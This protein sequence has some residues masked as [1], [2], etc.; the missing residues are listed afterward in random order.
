MT[1]AL[2]LSRMQ[3]V[4]IMDLRSNQIGDEGAL[5][6]S[7]MQ[8]ATTMDLKF[9]QIGDE[10]IGHL[11]SM[12]CDLRYQQSSRLDVRGAAQT[13]SQCRCTIF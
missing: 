4:S 10:G 3:G 13:S 2:Y 9:N 6:L 5:Y 7:R 12:A 8:G 11:S 1:G